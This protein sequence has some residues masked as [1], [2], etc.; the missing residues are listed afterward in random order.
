MAQRVLDSLLFSRFNVCIPHNE[1]ACV[2]TSEHNILTFV[3]VE[4][5]EGS[6]LP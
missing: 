4:R 5:E 1:Q 6:I 2:Q 3:I